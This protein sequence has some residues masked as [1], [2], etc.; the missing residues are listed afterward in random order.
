MNEIITPFNY[1]DLPAP[2]A[3]ELEAVT[4]R[5]K[6]R[7]TRTVENIIDIGGDLTL[8]KKRLGHGHFLA[9]IDTEFR[10]SDQTA[11][12]FMN[13]AKRFSK[14]KTVLDLPMTQAALYVLAAPST[15]DEVVD[16]ALAKAEA[17]EKIGK[18][19]VEGLKK[20][21]TEQ[22][23]KATPDEQ[24]E[25]VKVV[26]LGHAKNVREVLPE[27]EGKRGK[28]RRTSAEVQLDNFDHSIRCISKICSCS[29]QI[30]VPSLD[31]KR[32]S[33][34]V[35]VLRDAGKHI[36]ESIEIIQHSDEENE[37]ARRK[38]SRPARWSDATS[39]AV[40]ALEEMQEMQSEYQEWLDT[41]PD[42]LQESAVAEKLA[43]VTE[44]DFDSAIETVSEAEDADLPLGFGRD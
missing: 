34:A 5:I 20:T 39:R 6:D 25:A 24:R 36:Q 29:P 44:I 40:T 21:L 11:R 15:E 35:A 41:L 42:N 43:S 37:P 2:V 30:N 17:G 7:L 3:A 14:S 33:L 16:A 12:N 23:A 27:T 19:E 4:G 13:V 32:Q 28:K 18:P 10:M 1:S 26:N 8:A 31:S 22:K 38:A 9:W